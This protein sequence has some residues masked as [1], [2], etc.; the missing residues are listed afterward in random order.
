MISILNFK[1]FTRGSLLGFFTLRYHGLSIQNCR[2]MSGK[3]G[4]P[5]W[6]A[7]PQIKVEQDGEN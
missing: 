1:P 6:F 5:A 2:L 3:D 7:F 4:G